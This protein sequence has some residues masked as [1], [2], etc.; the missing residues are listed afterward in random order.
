MPGFKA[1]LA[2]T[3][4]AANFAAP[5]L[6]HPRA[7]QRVAV[8]ATTSSLGLRKIWK[9][10]GGMAPSQDD[11][12]YLAA[13]RELQSD[14][15][16]PRKRRRELRHVP[17]WAE[18]Q[19][20]P[21]D[22]QYADVEMV[23]SEARE[24]VA[25]ATAVGITD[26]TNTIHLRP[27]RRTAT[28]AEDSLKV[29]PRKRSSN[30]KPLQ[31]MWAKAATKTSKPQPLP[32]SVI[33][34]EK[35]QLEIEIHVD[36]TDMSHIATRRK[37]RASRR[38]SMPAR[39]RF[40]QMEAIDMDSPLRPAKAS[41]LNAP[42]SSPLKPF[43]MSDTLLAPV[44]TVRESIILKEHDAVA[45]PDDAPAPLIIFDQAVP[46][47]VTEPA[48]E[49]RRRR[50]LH[51][52]RHSEKW[53]EAAVEKRLS[54][55][56]ARHARRSMGA[57]L[58]VPKSKKSARRHSAHPGTG[59]ESWAGRRSSDCEADRLVHED[60][61]LQLQEE[62]ASASSG[63]LMVLE[64][65]SSVM[66]EEPVVV[67]VRENL[68]IFGANPPIYPLTAGNAEPNR[69]AS[70]PDSGLTSENEV[71]TD[72]TLHFDLAETSA[73]DSDVRPKLM[74]SPDTASRSGQFD[75]E[76]L[77]Q[78]PNMTAAGS[79]DATGQ[80]L[81]LLA[82]LVPD[83]TLEYGT[84]RFVGGSAI[85][86]LAM[87]IDSDAEETEGDDSV[88]E[89]QQQ[90][91]DAGNDDD[92]PN[93]PEPFRKSGSIGSTASSSG[94]PVSKKADEASS[95]PSSS[96]MKNR[97]PFAKKDLNA[98]PSP[99]KKR[100]SLLDGGSSNS[101]SGDKEAK[102]GK[103]HRLR[104]LLSAPSLEDASPPRPKRRRKKMEADTG[105]I[106]NPEFLPAGENVDV[107]SA[108]AATTAETV[109]T[110]TEAA[111]AEEAGL[112][113]SKR[114]T[115]SS[116]TAKSAAAAAVLAGSSGALSLLPVRLPGSLNL[117]GDEGHVTG[118]VLRRTGEKDVAAITRVNTR[119]NRAGAEHPSAVLARQAQELKGKK[120]GKGGKGRK[121]KGEKSQKGQKN[122]KSVTDTAEGGSE[123]EDKDK[124]SGDQGEV[125][126]E[127]K[128]DNKDEENDENKDSKSCKAKTV[129]WA[130]ELVRVQGR[131]GK[132]KK[133]KGKGKKDKTDK[134][135][136]G[137]KE[138]KEQVAERVE[139]VEKVA[140][141]ESCADVQEKQPNEAPA[142][143]AVAD[144]VAVDVAVD[145]GA[146]VSVA[147]P[148]EE[149]TVV[150]SAIA[151]ATATATAE[152]A[153]KKAIPRRTT[154]TSR[155]QLPT[156]RKALLS[157]A[158]AA[159]K[160]SAVKPTAAKTLAVKGTAVKATAVKATAVKAMAAKGTAAKATTAATAA[161]DAA[162][163][164]KLAMPRMATRRTNILS[165]GISGNGTPAPKRRA[166]RI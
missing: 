128:D 66:R 71:V 51:S 161:A 70:P 80:N 33:V 135:A 137:S 111:T 76:E 31:P 14:S 115:R 57:E 43:K 97:M 109:E 2:S 134:G 40:D 47:T 103:T 77:P 54:A 159:A 110:T 143:A 49:R 132:S 123:S 153:K 65:E 5:P 7:W 53:T 44:S 58:L 63:L 160:S 148:T 28:F 117:H 21:Q 52:G 157:A 82:P 121:T 72:E 24:A 105:G 139:H 56:R 32:E 34:E 62:T 38:Y 118:L 35:P 102:A 87:E 86:P 41:T 104:D 46:E 68:D 74:S 147:E 78:S 138:E 92:V 18:A 163:Q 120:G 98:S 122:Q 15:R 23:L 19:W 94:S 113:R 73:A 108:D 20:H 145:V 17:V 101:S 29:V 146:V 90:S 126:G 81:A 91:D 6:P 114:T 83:D 129:R 59:A 22:V 8:S 130:E 99:R 84:A 45:P 164:S 136:K 11:D 4:T 150:D 131:E 27:T 154:R 100:K 107:G 88:L 165:M 89:Q 1:D 155:L 42:A 141:A 93:T 96:L 13:V 152:P 116:Q 144:E 162:G 95:S 119:K 151:T 60:A 75:D 50:S 25:T 10:V 112:R 3:I 69:A 26:A 156:P 124:E 36:E 12:R 67:D 48:H 142:T 9:R 16:S 133:D 125:E 79:R 30:R 158:A 85:P 64:E 127:I 55:G 37:R 39:Q 61:A 166:G 106:F 149:A 140:E